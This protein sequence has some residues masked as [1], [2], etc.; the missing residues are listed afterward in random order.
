[1]CVFLLWNQIELIQERYP[2]FR[3]RAAAPAHLYEQQ[4][5][6]L[7]VSGDSSS[8]F[9]TFT[10]KK[11][12]QFEGKNC[13]RIRDMATLTHIHNNEIKCVL[14]RQVTIMQNIWAKY[15]TQRCHRSRNYTR[16]LPES[17]DIS[18]CM[19]RNLNSPTDSNSNPKGGIFISHTPTCA[20]ALSKNGNCVAEPSG[21]SRT[22]RLNIV[23]LYVLLRLLLGHVQPPDSQWNRSDLRQL[24]P[25]G[26]SASASEHVLLQLR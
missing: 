1:M 15:N 5:C 18:T 25:S 20:R 7:R 24:N 14:I 19:H 17:W 16:A 13:T 10:I 11:K 8:P 6:R 9:F 23:L 22:C 21:Y 2:T 3:L 4:V 12:Y 26:Q